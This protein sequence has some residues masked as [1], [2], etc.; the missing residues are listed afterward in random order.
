[1][2]VLRLSLGDLMTLR[3]G[4]AGFAAQLLEDAHAQES[5]TEDGREAYSPPAPMFQVTPAEE[6][7][8]H[9]LSQEQ[10][11]RLTANNAQA[12]VE[13]VSNRP[14]T[15]FP[16][17]PLPGSVSGTVMAKL[18]AG[19][20][21]RPTTRR[22]SKPAAASTAGRAV[23]GA[24]DDSSRP[25]TALAA[26]LLA[27]TPAPGPASASLLAVDG[28]SARPTTKRSDRSDESGARPLTK[29]SERPDTRATASRGGKKVVP[30]ETAL[31]SPSQLESI[32]QLQAQGYYL[33]QADQLGDGSWRPGT[34]AVPVRA[35]G[36]AARDGPRVS[37]SRR[38]PRAPL[39]CCGRA[40][41]PEVEW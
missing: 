29:R 24:R 41:A 40:A 1:M 27:G 18:L 19:K 13:N 3:L 37:R 31:M 6:D 8:R 9:S 33:P 22:D 38:P 28:A 35:S 21:D 12:P 15:T 2:I 4:G 34:T 20:D 11:G 23:D 39:L 25:S 17:A 14:P 5:A 36:H 26:Q 30:T 10:S 16:G 32:R 7:G